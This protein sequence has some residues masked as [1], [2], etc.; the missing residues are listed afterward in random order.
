MSHSVTFKQLGGNHATGALTLGEGLPVFQVSTMR[1][2][3]DQDGTDR[4]HVTVLHDGRAIGSGTL[5]AADGEWRGV[6]EVAK[7]KW[8]VRGVVGGGVLEFGEAAQVEG[9][10]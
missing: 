5:V 1:D 7:R 9:R 10:R 8:L 4:L 6:V 2:R 3:T